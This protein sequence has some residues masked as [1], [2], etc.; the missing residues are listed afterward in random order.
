[1]NSI[2]AQW[3]DLLQQTHAVRDEIWEVIDDSALQHRM[4]GNTLTLGGLCKEMGEVEYAY[5]QS[6]RNFTQDFNYRSDEVGLADSVDKLRAWY[7]QLDE[8]F[9]AVL[10][11]L[12]EDDIQDMRID[13][14]DGQLSVTTNF[15]FYR[16]GLLM[17]CAKV[18]IYLR[19]LSIQPPERFN[20]WIG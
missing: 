12:S 13:R 1:M 17:F 14:E 4:G 9:Y 16:E 19:S 18:S 8:E 5:I 11:E 3:F 6:F 7:S 15:H 10:L 20:A 2:V